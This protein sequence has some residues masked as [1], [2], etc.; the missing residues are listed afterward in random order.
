V[1]VQVL[2]HGV[3]DQLEEPDEFLV[4][5]LPVRLGYRRQRVQVQ[6]D[7]VAARR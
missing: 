4:P 2:R 6:A 3:V 7:D 1:A 5:V